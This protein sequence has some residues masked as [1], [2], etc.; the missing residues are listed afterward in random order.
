M[1]GLPDVWGLFVSKAYTNKL[2]YHLCLWHLDLSIS[3]WHFLARLQSGGAYEC[4]HIHLTF[5]KNFSK[6]G[7]KRH[8][9]IVAV[10]HEIG[11]SSLGMHFA[12]KNEYFLIRFSLSCLDSWIIPSWTLSRELRNNDT[13]KNK[14]AI[15]LIISLCVKINMHCKLQAMQE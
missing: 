2:Q 9:S 8:F 10:H 5:V 6:K 7:I 14:I 4:A 11:Q 12:H 1:S 3:L 15:N 13:W